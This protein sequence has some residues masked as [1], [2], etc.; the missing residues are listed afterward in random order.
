MV[1]YVGIN[2]SHYHAIHGNLHMPVAYESTHAEFQEVT[3]TG[4]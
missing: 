4:K 2:I 3:A 1:A